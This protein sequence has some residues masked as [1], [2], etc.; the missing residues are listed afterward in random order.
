MQGLGK[1]DGKRLFAGILEYNARSRRLLLSI[2]E[3]SKCWVDSHARVVT[4][5]QIPSRCRA[6]SRSRVL[7]YT[8]SLPSSQHQ[9]FLIFPLAIRYHREYHCNEEGAEKPAAL[10][11]GAPMRAARQNPAPRLLRHIRRAR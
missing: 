2:K 7:F 6:A 5:A 1:W 3:Q 11:N 4:G 10:A 9:P 8:L